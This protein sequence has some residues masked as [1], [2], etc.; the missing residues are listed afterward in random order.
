[1]ERAAVSS[2]PLGSADPGRL[3]AWY[4]AALAPNHQGEGPI[5]FGGDVLYDRQGQVARP[6]KW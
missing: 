2:L 3:R 4:C 6:T 5:T 1:M